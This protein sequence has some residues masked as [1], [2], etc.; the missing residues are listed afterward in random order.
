MS[1]GRSSHNRLQLK[2][3]K[4]LQNKLCSTIYILQLRCLADAGAGLKDS[5][6]DED[7]G[8]IGFTM[9]DAGCKLLPVYVFPLEQTSKSDSSVKTAS[10]FLKAER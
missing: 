3:K 6:A 5:G 1:E 8:M 7:T 4:R 2:K 10:E 9:T